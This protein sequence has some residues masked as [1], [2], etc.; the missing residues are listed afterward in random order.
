MLGLGSSFPVPLTAA[1]GSPAT[2]KPPGQ[3]GSV[4]T[5]ENCL[6]SSAGVEED[7]SS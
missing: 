6:S 3:S 2:T 4:V 7:L 5:I 1:W